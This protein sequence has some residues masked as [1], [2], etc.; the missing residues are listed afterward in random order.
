MS[1]PVVAAVRSL[2]PDADVAEHRSGRPL[3][4]ATA[5]AVVPGGGSKMVVPGDAPSTAAQ[6]LCR[7]SAASSA[8]DVVSRL[9]AAAAVRAS[10]GAVLRTRLSIA[11]DTSDSL[12][13]FLEDLLGEP[14]RFSLSVGSD[15]VNRKPVLEIFDTAGRSLAFAKLG[16]STLSRSDV[17][18][19]GVH[20]QQVQDRPWSRLVVPRVLHETVWRD[21]VVLVLSA[22]PTGR[23][24]V[25]RAG[26]PP[27]AAMNELAAAFAQ[28]RTPLGA[29]PWTAAQRDLAA[30]LP[31][32]GW[33]RRLGHCLRTLVRRSGD[34]PLAI[35]AWHGDWTPWNMT[36]SGDRVHLWD[37]ERFETGVPAG[38]DRLHYLVNEHTARRGTTTATVLA[39]LDR[40]GPGPDGPDLLAEV[41]LAAVTG[42]YLTLAGLPRGE[43]IA[44]RGRCTLAAL[45]ARLS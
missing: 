7:F 40:A 37:W 39:A 11:G 26:A 36:R 4:G 34:R 38:L 23:P 31:D 45:E 14:L 30:R 24:R 6:A 29:L 18:A 44:E 42:R 9:T 2:W 3:P 1:S 41:Y 22:L 27:V 5:L 33:R 20:L 10:R 32:D 16:S 13:T 21:A 19:E 43:G 28:V 12:L 8:R 17:A 35:G 25:R 15:R